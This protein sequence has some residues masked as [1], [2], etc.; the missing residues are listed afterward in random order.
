MKYLIIALSIMGLAA[1]QNSPKNQVEHLKATYAL[2]Q[3]AQDRETVITVLTQWVAQDSAVDA[4]VLDTL[5]YYHYFYKVIPGVVRS[6]KT[7][8]FYTDKGLLRSPN[9]LFLRD[10]KAKL[11]L[12]EGKDTAAFDMFT[13]MWNETKDPTYFWDL[14]WIQIARG[15]MQEADSMI[16]MAMTD[17]EMKSKKVSMEHIQA[18]LT[19]K[20]PTEAAFL[21]LKY[22]LSVANRNIMQGAEFLQKALEI[23]PNF[24]AARRSI[25]DLQR[26]SAAGR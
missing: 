5:A 4:W 12:E 2:A 15:R 1:C 16:N 22:Q 10:I 17:A 6:S 18:Q 7:P 25:V 26:M 19:E 11:L 9:S 23:E 3:E 13:A 20:V 24:Y 14:T 21:F 8:L